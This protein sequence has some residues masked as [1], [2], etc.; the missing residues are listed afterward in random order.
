MKYLK[1]YEEI[2]NPRLPDLKKLLDHLVEVFTNIGYYHNNFFSDELETHFVT[3]DSGSRI[4]DLKGN[5]SRAYIIISITMRSASNAY[6]EQIQEY[7]KTIEG[8]KIY[9]EDKDWYRISFEI[10]G[11]VDN[12]ISQITEDSLKMFLDAK[13]YNIG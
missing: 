8:L 3:K 7:F 10:F 13:K 11:D 1:L 6:E 9:S 2:N 5:F 12:I 4:F